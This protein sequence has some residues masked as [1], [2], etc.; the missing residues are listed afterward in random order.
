M[1]NTATDALKTA[2]DL[3]TKGHAYYMDIAS[4]AD[5]PLTQSVF[6][7]LAAQELIHMQRIKDLYEGRPDAEGVSAIAHGELEKA[8]QEIFDK[9]TSEQREAWAMD[10]AAAYDYAM[11][12]ERESAAMYDK[13]ARESANPAEAQFFQSLRAEENEHL[14]ALENVSGYLGHTGDWFAVEET[15]VWNWMNM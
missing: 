13:F 4:K 5:N 11:K 9:F 3:E 8:V 7:S 14:A 2:L 10:N 15:R 6:F 1:N 12:L